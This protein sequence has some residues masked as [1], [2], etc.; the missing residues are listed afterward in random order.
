MAITFLLLN[1]KASNLGYC[2]YLLQSLS[3][4]RIVFLAGFLKF[5]NCSCKRVFVNYAQ[6]IKHCAKKPI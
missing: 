3:I 2:V 6:L 4:K 1:L 5:A